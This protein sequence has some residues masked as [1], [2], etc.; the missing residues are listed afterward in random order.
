MIFYGLLK[1]GCLDPDNSFTVLKWL[2]D[3]VLQGKSLLPMELTNVISSVK[4][5]LVRLGFSI[6]DTVT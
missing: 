1:L 4:K 2:Y 5:K 3:L 6:I